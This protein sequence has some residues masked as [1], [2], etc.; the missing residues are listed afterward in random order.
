MAV[1]LRQG[2]SRLATLVSTDDANASYA[3]AKDLTSFLHF[4]VVDSFFVEPRA[5]SPRLLL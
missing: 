4:L 2:L 5:T 1:L 3:E